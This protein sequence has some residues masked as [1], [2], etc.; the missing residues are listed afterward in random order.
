MLEFSLSPEE[1][2]SLILSC[3]KNSCAFCFAVSS[4]ISSPVNPFFSWLVKCSENAPSYINPEYSWKFS[5]RLL[6]PS[7]DVV[8]TSCAKALLPLSANSPHLILPEFISSD[9]WFKVFSNSILYECS[10]SKFFKSSSD[11]ASLYIFFLDN[12]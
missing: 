10:S 8:L 1:V 3:P 9:N 7:F 6:N 12:E 2:I 5:S 4:S 11:K